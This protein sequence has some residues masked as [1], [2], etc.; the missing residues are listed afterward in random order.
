M[1]E[2]VVLVSGL[3]TTSVL[4]LAVAAMARG[5]PVLVVEA[6]A[7]GGLGRETLQAETATTI[8]EMALMLERMES[9]PPV[10]LVEVKTRLRHQIEHREDRQAA[11]VVRA[12]KPA[13]RYRGHFPRRF[14]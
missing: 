9:E 12:L 5:V 10:A 3:S 8:R 2:K 7:E 6:S 4:T 1:R 11:R 14:G 13:V